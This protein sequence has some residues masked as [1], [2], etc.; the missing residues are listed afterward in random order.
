MEA[1]IFTR[2]IHSLCILPFI[3]C[4]HC[5]QTKNNTKNG[6]PGL[7]KIMQFEQVYSVYYVAVQLSLLFTFNVD[8]LFRLADGGGFCQHNGNGCSQHLLPKEGVT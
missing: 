3:E 2:I 1:L 8:P 7:Q 4:N 6:Y 5:K